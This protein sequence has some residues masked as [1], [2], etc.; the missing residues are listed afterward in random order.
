MDL[1]RDLSSKTVPE[2]ARKEYVVACLSPFPENEIVIDSAARCARAFNADFTAV[3][4]ETSRFIKLSSE[5]RRILNENIQR[6]EE[7][8]ADIVTLQGD[9]ESYMIGEFCRISH[10]T[11]VVIGRAYEKRPLFGGAARLINQLRAQI[12]DAEIHLVATPNSWRKPSAVFRQFDS[13]FGL[14]SLTRMQITNDLIL[15]ICILGI[16]VIVGI[17]FDNAGFDDANIVSIFILAIVLISLSAKRAIMTMFSCLAAI[18]LF[19]Y[20]FAMPRGSFSVYNRGYIVTFGIVFCTS[21][22]IG[23]LVQSTKISGELSANSARRTKTLFD[24]N[25]ELQR[26]V[27]FDDV[28]QSALRHIAMMTGRNTAFFPYDPETDQM[29]DPVIYSL[30][31]ST[32]MSRD[33][34][35]AEA[36]VALE[37]V[38]ASVITGASTTKHPDA[39]F[40]YLPAETDEKKYGAVCVELNYEVLDEMESSIAK[41]IVAEGTMTAENIVLRRENREAMVRSR[42][43]EIRARLL[44]AISHDLRTPLTAISGNIT[45]LTSSAEVFTEEQKRDMYQEINSNTVWLISLIENLLTASRFE[46]GEITINPTAELLDD[47]VREVL[48]EPVHLADQHEIRYEPID[49]LLM[50]SIDAQMIR[51]LLVNLISNAAEHTPPGTRITIRTRQEGGQAVIEV[52]D[53]GPGIPDADKPNIF[54]MF[55]IGDKKIVDSRRSMGLGLF[56]CKNIANAH[57]G[58]LT[59]TDN[60]PHGAVFS[61]YLPV[62]SLE[63][64]QVPEPSMS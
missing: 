38:Q 37:A 2:S 17:A 22:L 49:D 36:P 61:L 6:A 57:Q 51:R 62:I 9:D 54:E 10:A 30:Y 14:G 3:F 60:D 12:P 33:R 48:S 32:A 40:L 23:Y 59:V 1:K 20:M 31:E 47:V 29:E 64:L 21:L 5:E 16:T 11:H 63:D 15:A 28:V 45:N 46:E 41:A 34:L 13:V 26:A 53:E 8:G 39:R 25:R 7:A 42:S 50:A 18:L 52:A 24:A 27:E 44:R 35:K 4:V 19:N 55:Y 43:E 58:K 56:L